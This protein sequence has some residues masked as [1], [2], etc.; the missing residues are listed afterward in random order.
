MHVKMKYGLSTIGVR[1]DHHTIA[2]RRKSTMPCYLG[3]DKQQVS[4]RLL[5][6]RTGLIERVNM[7]ARNYQ[8]MCRSLRREVVKSNANVVLKYSR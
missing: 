8:N 7:N 6:G 5:L 2:V 4:E 1:I 3:G